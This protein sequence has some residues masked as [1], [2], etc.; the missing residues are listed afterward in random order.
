MPD[1]KA[2]TRNLVAF[3][4]EHVI[5]HRTA[6]QVSDAHRDGTVFVKFRSYMTYDSFSLAQL[7]NHR[8]WEN[9]KLFTQ[10]DDRTFRVALDQFR[11]EEP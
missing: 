6:F 4:M 8:L 11:S 2:L 10:M 3:I 5:G 1:K 9:K 7:F